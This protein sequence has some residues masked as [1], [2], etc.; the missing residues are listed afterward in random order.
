MRT[1]LYIDDDEQYAWMIKTLLGKRGFIV[2]TA[3]DGLE[4]MRK[5]RQLQPDL[6]LLDM[7]LP[8]IDGLEVVEQ[9][10]SESPT[11]HIPIVVMSALPTHSSRKLLQGV[12]VQDVVS[13]PFQLEE[14]LNTVSR[15]LAKRA[16]TWNAPSPANV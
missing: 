1:I 16:V 11:R 14:L 10:R 13:K 9:L 8:R 12:D 4:G 6:I 5:A 3:C 2:E 15:N 7:Y